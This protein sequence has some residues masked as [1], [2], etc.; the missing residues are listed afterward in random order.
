MICSNCGENGHNKTNKSCPKNMIVEYLP[1]MYKFTQTRIYY[2]ISLNY[3]TK[4]YPEVLCISLIDIRW[5]GDYN[6][7]KKDMTLAISSLNKC[8]YPYIFYNLSVT[9][10]GISHANSILINTRKGT[11]SRYEPHGFYESWGDLDVNLSKIAILNN[12]IYEPPCI[13]CPFYGVQSMM[14]DNVGFCQT[15]VLYN[16]LSKLDKN[17]IY[18][19]TTLSSEKSRKEIISLIVD[20]LLNIYKK[21]PEE[22]KSLFLGYSS[23]NVFQLNILN[24]AII[25]TQI[26]N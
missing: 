19:T 4:I 22:L 8:P 21:L 1:N 12:V 2:L 5:T 6:I 25:N 24:E 20:L 26:Q 11:F 18:L 3:I 15:A 9:Y 16:L 10:K 23:L 13:T 7:L 14:K 17:Y